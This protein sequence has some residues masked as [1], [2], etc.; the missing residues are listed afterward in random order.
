MSLQRHI[1]I[2][3][4]RVNVTV[5]LCVLSMERRHPVYSCE[6]KR[7]PHF[8]S[9]M[10]GRGEPVAVPWSYR[11]CSG[12]FG[13]IGFQLKFALLPV[14]TSGNLKIVSGLLDRCHEPSEASHLQLQQGQGQVLLNGKS[15]AQ[16]PDPALSEITEVCA[17]GGTG[18]TVWWCEES[19]QMGFLTKM[20]LYCITENV[21]LCRLVGGR[22][23]LLIMVQHYFSLLIAFL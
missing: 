22:V 7:I 11:N 1:L 3:A 19:W 5:L 23:L 8:A 17:G 2:V 18:V 15:G 4:L 21:V 10:M 16:K 20:T 14:E 9:Q 6:G 13:K 12:P